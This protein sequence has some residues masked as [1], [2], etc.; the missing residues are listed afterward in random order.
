MAGPTF[1]AGATVSDVISLGGPAEPS[2]LI[3]PPNWT[4]AN[5]SFLVSDDNV[6]FYPLYKNGALWQLACPPGAALLLSG[7]TRWPKILYMKFVS[8]SPDKP[9]VQPELCAFKILT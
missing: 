4:I 2:I 6:T 7:D 3:T 8:G 9:I 1:A 5:L